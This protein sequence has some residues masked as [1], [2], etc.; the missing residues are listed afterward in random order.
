MEVDDGVRS[1][2][3]DA[4]MHDI[5]R[6]LFEMG[7]ESAWEGEQEDELGGQGEIGLATELLEVTSEEEL[8]RFL[9]DV[10]KSAVSAGKAF[11]SSDAGRAV[12]GLLKSAAKQALPHVGRAVGGA[13][14][15]LGADAGSKVGGFL[16]GKL[17][18]E[19][20]GLSQ[21]DRELEVS[22]AFVRFADETARIAAAA[23]PGVPPQVAAQRAA[24]AAARHHLPPLGPVIAG[25]RPPQ[26]GGPARPGG[27]R[28]HSGRWVRRGRN[29]VL[30][31]A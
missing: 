7:Q 15:W 29:I 28:K 11:I 18:A 12:G 3:R 6:A 16:A 30:L 13:V 20:E 9:G 26:P 1:G 14:P 10:L 27:P 8:D 17:E 31:D 5:D 4:P 23:P 21:E 2:E 25:M 24:I 19:L 22:R